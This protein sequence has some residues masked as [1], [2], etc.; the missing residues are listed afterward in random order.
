MVILNLYVYYTVM[1]CRNGWGVKNRVPLIDWKLYEFFH[2]KLALRYQSRL[3]EHCNWFCKT[4]CGPIAFCCSLIVSRNGSITLNG[5]FD[6]IN[7]LPGNPLPSWC[8][9]DYQ[10]DEI[11][12]KNLLT[13]AV[14]EPLKMLAILNALTITANGKDTT[15]KLIGL[16]VTEN[17]LRVLPSLENWLTLIDP[18][19]FECPN[20]QLMS[21][22]VDIEMLSDQEV[23]I[24]YLDETD[25]TCELWSCQFETA[26]SA[27]STLNAIE[28][29]WSKLFGVPL[30]QPKWYDWHVEAPGHGAICVH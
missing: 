26:D 28:Q 29:S 10:T 3:V 11:L 8:S 17:H 1:M 21:N 19:V 12:A 23:R 4:F 30:T 18:V 13:A 9:L 2:G 5:V 6:L 7:P 20:T 16:I 24:N 27:S 22:L 14:D 25:D 15:R